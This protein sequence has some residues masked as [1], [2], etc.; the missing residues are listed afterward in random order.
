MVSVMVLAVVLVLM[1][2]GGVDGGS[3]DSDPIQW[4]N[5]YPDTWLDLD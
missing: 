5:I 1:L 2:V 3:I 4:L